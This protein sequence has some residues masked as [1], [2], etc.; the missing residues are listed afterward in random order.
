M[1]TRDARVVYLT[2]ESVTALLQTTTWTTAAVYLI[3]VAHLGALQLVLLGTIMEA[4]IFLFEI[5]TGV[6]ADTAGRRLSVIIGTVVMGVGLLL[7]GAVPWFPA[8]L[9]SQALWGIGETFTSGATAAWLAGEVGDRAAG[10][11]F[12]RAAQYRRVAA[13]AG[14]GLAVG[15]A[16]LGLGLPLIAGGAIQIAMGGWLIAAMPETGFRRANASGNGGG[17]G[18]ESVG[19]GEGRAAWRGLARTA[20]SGLSVARSDRVLLALLAVAVLA[21]ASTEGIDRLW[22]LH[23]L[24]EVGFPAVRLSAVTWFGIIQVVSLAIGAAVIAPVR[25]RVDV[26]DPAALCRL[27]VVLTAIEAVGLAVFGAATGFGPAIAAYLAYGAA[28]GLRD[29]LYD[30]WVVPMIEPSVRATVLSTIGQADAVG[31]TLGGPAIGLIAT[32]ATPGAAIVAAGAALAPAIAVLARLLPG[33]RARAR[34][35][36]R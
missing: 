32:L 30:A 13:A 26:T 2:L 29:P 7:T 17:A 23:L 20:R 14:I 34:A 15:L 8:L 10:P 1:R 33:R 21:G 28:R 36:N 25:R 19:E 31:E 22:E 9:A 5:P 6:V 4:S 35:A 27:L 3:N 18:A 11:L 24:G 12:L 16:N